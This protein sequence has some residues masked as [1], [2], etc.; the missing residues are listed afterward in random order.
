VITE[1]MLRQAFHY[2]R[3]LYCCN[4]MCTTT[5]IMRDENRVFRDDVDAD[6]KARLA[7]IAKQLRPRR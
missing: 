5:T 3:W 2:A 7:D 4:P 6:T 1:K